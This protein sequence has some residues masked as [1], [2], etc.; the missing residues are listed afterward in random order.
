MRCSL[1]KNRCDD[2]VMRKISSKFD[3]FLMRCKIG[4]RETKFY[5][6][7]SR[8]K[9]SIPKFKVDGVCRADVTMLPASDQTLSLGTAVPGKHSKIS[10]SLAFF[11]NFS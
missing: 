2:D 9:S 1:V 3:E 6:K 7:F 5:F 8:K 11:G 10:A 4:N